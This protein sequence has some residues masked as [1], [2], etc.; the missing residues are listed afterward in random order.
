MRKKNKAACYVFPHPSVPDKDTI[1]P[2][3]PVPDEDTIEP[4]TSILS[5]TPDES[6]GNFMEVMKDKQPV[7]VGNT[8]RSAFS[9]AWEAFRKKPQ[10]LD[11]DETA[12][13]QQPVHKHNSL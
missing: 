12:L 7:P 11:L 4:N 1:K 10:G 9:G 2:E 13:K 3:Q 8:I 6:N 5:Q